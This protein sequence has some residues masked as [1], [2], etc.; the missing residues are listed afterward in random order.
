MI[1]GSQLLSTYERLRALGL[2]NSREEFSTTWCERGPDYLRDYTRRRG[3]MARVSPQTVLRLR[4]NLA[5]A[6]CLLPPAVAAE[7]RA[8]DAMIKRDIGVADAVGRWSSRTR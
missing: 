8:V 3:A 6:A 2:A 4:S 7:V 5:E 1:Y